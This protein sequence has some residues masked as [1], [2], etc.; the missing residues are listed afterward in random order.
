M[1]SFSGRGR[2]LV[3][4]RYRC[5]ETKAAHIGG[6]FDLAKMWT[7]KM[8]FVRG[9]LSGL[10][11]IDKQPGNKQRFVQSV[12][13]DS[14]FHRLSNASRVDERRNYTKHDVERRVFEKGFTSVYDLPDR[15]MLAFVKNRVTHMR[16][17]F[18]HRRPQVNPF[19]DKKGKP[20]VKIE[21]MTR[22]MTMTRY[23]VEAVTED[24]VSFN[25]NYQGSLGA[26]QLM[27]C[28]FLNDNISA[29]CRI[30]SNLW[31]S[32]VC[33]TSD[34]IHAGILDTH[35]YRQNCLGSDVRLFVPN[36]ELSVSGDN[37]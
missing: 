12:S 13:V 15:K 6:Q 8:K 22:S 24:A 10:S 37:V 33:T 35:A 36:D 14:F 4:H 20:L 27:V 11:S 32:N 9:K 3:L 16:A 25:I 17:L 26:L 7:V 5:V 29:G 18:P 1:T 31:T 21:K 19:L 2:A 30:A 23:K 28:R 34:T